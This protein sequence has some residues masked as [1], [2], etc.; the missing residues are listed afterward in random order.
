MMAEKELGSVEIKQT[1]DLQTPSG[2]EEPRGR[3]KYSQ[4]K[5]WK[6]TLDLAKRTVKARPDDHLSDEGYC[7]TDG[8]DTRR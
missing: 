5:G 7:Q 1:G 6:N 8:T 4:S 3:T 2:V